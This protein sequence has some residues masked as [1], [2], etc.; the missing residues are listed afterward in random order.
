MLEELD[1]LHAE[2]G[3]VGDDSGNASGVDRDDGDADDCGYAAMVG[4]EGGE[5]ED[6]DGDWLLRMA[7]GEDRDT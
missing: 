1:A 3:N 6:E 7:N 2:V 4:G 5:P